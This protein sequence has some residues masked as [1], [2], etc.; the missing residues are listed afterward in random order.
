MNHDPLN[1]NERLSIFIFLRERETKSNQINTQYII[2]IVQS[3]RLIFQVA[4]PAPDIPSHV[5]I[6]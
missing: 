3:F 1:N 2:Q 5:Y 4:Q 6:C